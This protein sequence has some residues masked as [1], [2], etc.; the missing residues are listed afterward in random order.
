MKRAFL[1]LPRPVLRPEMVAGL[2]AFYVA[3][4]LN[5]V[6]WS[7][8]HD[9][10]APRI[11]ADYLFLAATPILLILLLALFFGA[12]AL[13][14]IL[15]PVGVTILIACAAASYFMHEYRVV[16]D[17][18]MVANVFQTDQ[19]EAGDLMT[20]KFFKSVA[21]YGI[22]PSV[23]LLLVRLDPRPFWPELKFKALSGTALAAAAVVLVGS[24]SSQL[25]S[26][27]RTNE[28]IRH[29]LLPFNIVGATIKYVRAHTA[30]TVAVVAKPFGADAVRGP[31]WSGRSRKSVTVLVIGETARAQNFS[32]IGYD[33]PTNPKLAANDRLI[34]FANVTSC[35]TATAQSLPC[36]FSGVGRSGSSSS[37][38]YT[39]EGLLDILQRSGFRMLWRDNQSGCKGVCARIPVEGVHAPGSMRFYEA[40]QT[41]DDRLVDGLEAWIDRLDGHGVVVLH[42]MGSHGPAY[43]KRYPDEFEVF[44]PACRDPQLGR[45]SRESIVNAYDNTILY[46]DHV[47]ARLIGV[48]EEQ[49]RKGVAAAMMYVSDHGESLGENGIYLHGMPF[50]IAPEFQTRVPWLMWLSERFSSDVGSPEACLKRLRD[51]PLSHDDFFH[52]V[53]GLLDVTTKVYH[54]KNDIFSRCAAP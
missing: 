39:Q 43:F 3:T 22:L 44:K 18:H 14:W 52:S 30:A 19:K 17:H 37:I 45:C 33:R 40:A 50:A 13:R 29:E 1:L 21:L 27:F 23:L 8:L 15:K 32:L 54:A 2:L 49:D 51:R 41:F 16:I 34:T 38:A 4:V 5:G 28:L 25:L 9:A 11:V 47:L 24:F 42:M 12:F 31:S 35:G 53:L 10:V 26:V 36:M 46:T 20:L 7:R 48:L 6:F